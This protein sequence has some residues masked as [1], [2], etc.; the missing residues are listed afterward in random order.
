IALAASMEGLL[1]RVPANQSL[2]ALLASIQDFAVTWLVQRRSSLR[3]SAAAA[4]D[5]LE[6]ALDRVTV[7]ATDLSGYSHV[8]ASSDG[9]F[10]VN[11][12]DYQ[13][14]VRGSFFGL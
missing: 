4:I 2:G 12:R 10:A 8:V 9:L 6:Y 11:D 13:K 3:G 5:R 14:I 7:L 1:G